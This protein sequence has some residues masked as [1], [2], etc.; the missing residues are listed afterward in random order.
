MDELAYALKIDPIELRLRNYAQRDEDENKEFSSK[1]LRACYEQGAARFGWKRRNPQPGQMRD[2]NALIGWGMATATYPTNRQENKAKIRLF[3]EG[4]AVVSTASQDL[5]TGTY[6]ILTQIAAQTLGLSPQRVKVEIGDTMYPQGA[7]SG[8]SQTAASAGS[9]VEAAAKELLKKLYALANADP[10]CPLHG[11]QL[12]DMAVG[13]DRVFLKKD[14]RT[15]EPV[16]ALLTRN[17][18]RPLDAQSDTKPGKTQEFST[19]AFGATFAEVR[20]DPDL[21]EIRVSRFVGAYAAG[22]ILNAKTAHSQ[23]MGGIVWGI[24]MAL[25]EHTVIEPR[26]GSVINCNLADYLVPTNADI[27]QIDCFFVPEKDDRVNPLGVK[28][29]GELGNTGSAAAVANA[30][31]HATGKRVRDLPV[32]LDK[33]L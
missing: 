31:Y 30:V 3:A 12:A 19:H 27:H 8:G 33:I 6:T 4:R 29:I 17:G 18:G 20:I 25:L 28:G 1:S 9:S 32:T 2:G 11:K 10:K 7:V 24:S 15:G 22:R 13:D 23:I 14:P 21:R 26:R 16:A 5:G